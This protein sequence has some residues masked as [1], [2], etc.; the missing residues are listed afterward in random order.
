MYIH[1]PFVP[2]SWIQVERVISMT[3]LTW[4]SLLC[5]ALLCSRADSLRSHV[6]L[7]EWIVFIMLFWI[8]TKVVYLQHWHGWCHMK[9][10]P[11][12]CI[13]CTP[14]NHASYHFM[15]SNIRKVH[16]YL[17]VTCH[18]HFWQNDWGL[19]RATAVTHG[20]NGYWNKSTESWPWI[21]KFSCRS[22][23]DSNP[24]PFGH[25]SGALTSELSP[26]HASWQCSL[27]YFYISLC[28]HVCRSDVFISLKKLIS[29]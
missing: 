10:L 14:Y 23:R 6:T 11:S 25:E 5:N 27:S 4:W 7:H 19:L 16:V 12:Q 17:A 22:C 28:L 21:R 9:L 24:R 15:Q 13:L 26:L 2:A 20:L 8:S 18:L 3:M 29:V 1:T